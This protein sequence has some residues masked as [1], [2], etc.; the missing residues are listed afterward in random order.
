MNDSHVSKCSEEKA[1]NQ[2]AY[3][4]FYKRITSKSVLRKDSGIFQE[5]KKEVEE[6]KESQTVKKVE[7]VEAKSHPV[8]N[9]KTK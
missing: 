9:G 5:E 3:L 6:V 8:M 4:L 2:Q 1:M 7:E